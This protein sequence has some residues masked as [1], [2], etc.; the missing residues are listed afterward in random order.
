MPVFEHDLIL[1]GYDDS[2]MKHFD[3]VSE[4]LQKKTL[5]SLMLKLLPSKVSG[6]SRVKEDDEHAKGEDDVVASVP[7]EVVNP[8]VGS[9]QMVTHNEK[10]RQSLKSLLIRLAKE[11][12][13]QKYKDY[14]AIYRSL[15]RISSNSLLH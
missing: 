13:N 11:K 2:I 7:E 3:Q 12:S 4:H 6:S 8:P 9:Q 5:A 14:K 15:A 10:K 1:L